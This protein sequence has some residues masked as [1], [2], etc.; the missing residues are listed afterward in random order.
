MSGMWVY[1]LLVKDEIGPVTEY[2]GTL[3]IERIL[4]EGIRGS[5][6]RKRSKAY[7]PNEL[8]DAKLVTY[9]TDN[10]EDAMAFAKRRAKQLGID[11][12]EIG[13]V[14]VKATSL[15]EPIEHID[16]FSKDRKSLVREGGI[17][18][19]Y[20]QRIDMQKAV[21]NSEN[22]RLINLVMRDGKARSAD[23]IVIEIRNLK[24]TSGNPYRNI[25]SS[26]FI[27]SI[28][29]R[30]SNYEYVREG[31]ITIWRYIGA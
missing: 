2:H 7:V 30:D 23:S 12:D 26:S 8:R 22:K 13:V 17:E 24:N 18:A 10:P 3:D 20:L 16:I 29:A 4:E 6:P 25:P 31:K 15:P 9:T 11:E 14:G 21:K 28:L 1:S 27:G 5:N 19:K